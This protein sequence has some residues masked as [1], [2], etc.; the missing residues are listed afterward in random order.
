MPGA[1]GYY[2]GFGVSPA[3]SH[4]LHNGCAQASTAFLSPTGETIG[5][6][7]GVYQ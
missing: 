1:C 5:V 3:V 4:A 7:V 6:P 2:L